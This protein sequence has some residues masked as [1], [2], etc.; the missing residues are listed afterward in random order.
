MRWYFFLLLLCL[1]LSLVAQVKMTVDDVIEAKEWG[2]SEDSILESLAKAAKEK[3]LQIELTK[4]N[5]L[6]LRNANFSRDFLRKIKEIVSTQ[7]SS[8][9]PALP[10]FVKRGGKK[11]P[12]ENASVNAAQSWAVVVGINEYKNDPAIANL[13]CAVNDAVSMCRYFLSLGLPEKQIIM[14][15]DKEATKAKIESVLQEV[16]KEVTYQGVFY[17]CFSGHG[18]PDTAQNLYFMTHDADPANPKETAYPMESLK[19][20]LKSKVPAQRVVAFLDACYSGGA[21]SVLRGQGEFTENFKSK[22]AQLVRMEK[23]VA[24]FASSQENQESYERG[25]HGLFTR[26]LLEGFEG[27]ADGVFKDGKDGKVTFNECFVYIINSLSTETRGG[28]LPSKSYSHNWNNSYGMPTFDSGEEANE[29]EIK[30]LRLEN[31]RGI[32]QQRFQPGEK[33]YAKISWEVKKTGTKKQQSISLSGGIQAAEKSLGEAQRGTWP[34]RIETR[35]SHNPGQHQ[36]LARV[37]IGEETREEK[38]TIEIAEPLQSIALE[39][40][41]FLKKDIAS[42]QKERAFESWDEYVWNMVKYMKSAYQERQYE[43]TRAQLQVL[44]R[45]S[46]EVTANYLQEVIGYVYWHEFWSH[47]QGKQWRHIESL[48]QQ[49]SRE[50]P[51][52]ERNRY[53]LAMKEAQRKAQTQAQEEAMQEV[54]RYFEQKDYDNCKRAIQRARQYMP[55]HPYLVWVEEEMNRKPVYQHPEGWNAGEWQECWKGEYLDFTVDTW[56]RKPW[57]EQSRLSKAYRAWYAQQKGLAEEKT[58]SKAGISIEM[59]L[60]PPGR[61]QMGSPGSEEGRFDWEKQH[62]VLISKPYYIGKYEVTKAQWQA[63]MGTG[64]QPY[65]KNSPSNAPMESISW[66]ECQDFCSKVGMSLPTE[67]QWEHACRSGVSKMTYQGDFSILG[68]NNGGTTLDRVAWYGGNSGVDYDGGYDSSGW[69][70]KQYNH[71]RAGVHAVGGKA[72]NAWGIHDMLGN[73]WEWCMDW[74]ADY[75]VEDAPEPV[76]PSTGSDRVCRGGSW[77]H[78]ARYC[79]AAYRRSGA[80]VGRSSNLGFRLQ[81]TF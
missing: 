26:F 59:C 6:R 44:K 53:V 33:V 69:S 36:I 74:K 3:R 9:L 21:K 67:A 73:V 75:A 61:F 27:K 20:Y 46:N 30:E 68:D 31:E 81:V 42:L 24:I 38:T 43:Q 14:L 22:T 56:T 37:K 25:G 54:K 2:G 39:P 64:I 66:T 11:G 35:A 40:E 7:S 47:I 28:Q 4:D 65:F 71:T 49:A 17:F 80:P 63:V 34:E 52:G 48:Y 76:G 8:S 19:E 50:L 18:G 79:R 41:D 58:M 57:E 77:S 13:K 29:F 10:D 1:S 51:G 72:A 23:E 70:G 62:R 78:D 15:T 60:V 5:Y 16:A 45:T 55:N 12:R 32:A